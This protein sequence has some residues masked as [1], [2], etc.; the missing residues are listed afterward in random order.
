MEAIVSSKVVY[1][2]GCQI[3][4]VPFLFKIMRKIIQYPDQTFLTNQQVRRET[5]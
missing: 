4:D 3:N 1:K 5:L 2:K